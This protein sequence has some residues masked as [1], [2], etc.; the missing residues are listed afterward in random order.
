M[1]CRKVL[2]LFLLKNILLLL[3][4][5]QAHGYGTT[6]PVAKSSECNLCL[7]IWWDVPQLTEP[8]LNHRLGICTFSSF[9]IYIIFSLSLFLMFFFLFC[10]CIFFEKRMTGIFWYFLNNIYT[11][12]TLLSCYT[13]QLY[14]ISWLFKECHSML[15]T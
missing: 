2:S 14:N 10:N 8:C 7:A 1:I 5:F 15:C 13:A 6:P 12:S 11:L 9:K 4:C 3:C